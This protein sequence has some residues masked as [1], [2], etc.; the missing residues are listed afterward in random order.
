M[1]ITNASGFD[2]LPDAAVSAVNLSRRFSGL[3][4][5]EALA[6]AGS[7]PNDKDKAMRFSVLVMS[8]A[9]IL[10]CIITYHHL[11]LQSRANI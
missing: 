3:A 9:S 2:D 1:V 10:D 6:V 7:H 8:P 4:W 5:W 11:R